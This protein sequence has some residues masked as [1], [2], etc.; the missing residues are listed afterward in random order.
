MKSQTRKSANKAI[1]VV[2]GIVLSTA[3]VK[4]AILM[5]P[6]TNTDFTTES[7]KAFGA[8][9]FLI[10]RFMEKLYDLY[11]PDYSKHNDIHEI[12]LPVSA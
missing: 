6:T 5:W 11:V 9:G 12:N 3:S 10:T 7:F 1:N 8:G 2:A 4:T